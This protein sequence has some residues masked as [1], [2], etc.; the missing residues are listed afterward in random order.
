MKSDAPGT[1][2]LEIEVTN[3]S[4]HGFWILLDDRELFLSFPKFP[5]FKEATIDQILDVEWPSSHHLYW[6]GLVDRGGVFMSD[7]PAS[8][9]W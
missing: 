9:A 1:H 2:T 3:I 8:R 7:C 4:K 5:W 6:P